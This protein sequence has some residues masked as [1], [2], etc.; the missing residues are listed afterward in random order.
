MNDERKYL[1]PSGGSHLLGAILALGLIVVSI[2]DLFSGCNAIMREDNVFVDALMVLM[3]LCYI[4][5]IE[6]CMMIAVKDYLFAYNVDKAICV[7]IKGNDLKSAVSIA[8]R[9]YGPIYDRNCEKQ[10]SSN[11]RSSVMRKCFY[12]AIVLMFAMSLISP[13]HHFMNAVATGV[14]TSKL[15]AALVLIFIDGAIIINRLFYRGSIRRFWALVLG[16]D[17]FRSILKFELSNCNRQFMPKSTIDCSNAVCYHD[18]IPGVNK[19]QPSRLRL[20]LTVIVMIVIVVTAMNMRRNR[21]RSDSVE[22]SGTP[23]FRV[24]DGSHEDQ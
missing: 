23:M 15:I 24:Y 6:A 20:V 22:R 7:L 8:R 2:Y 5:L 11:P 3:L 13:G 17:H 19:R 10:F 12:A 16:D 18:Y 9:L 4:S 14:W 21:D 1:F